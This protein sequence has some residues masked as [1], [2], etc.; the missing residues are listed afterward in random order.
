MYLTNEEE[1]MLKGEQG[2]II[3]KCMKLLLRLGEIYGADRMIKISS[4]QAAGVSYKSIGDPGL[5]FLK[6]FVN[7]GAKVKVPTFLNPA[8]MDLKNW[9]NFGIS[10]NFAEKQLE[11]INTFKKMGIIIACSCTPYLL[12]NL[13]RVGEHIA[14]SESSAVS[15]ANSVIGA[16]TNREGGPSALAA[17]IT[18]RTPNYGFHIDEN[19]KPNFL[20][21]VNANLKT[22]SDYGALGF[23]I[24]KSVKNKVPFFEGIKETDTDKLKSLGAAMA[25]SGGVALYHVLNKTPEAE[26][27]KPTSGNLEKIEFSEKDLK[28]SYEELSDSQN[29]DLIV[30]GCPH[31]SISE[32]E[33]L[34]KKLKNKKLKKEFWI[35]TSKTAK[36]WA[37]RMGYAKILECSG[38]KIICDSCM[39]VSP[40]EETNFECVGTNSGKAA[41]YLPGFCK[42]KVFFGNLDS[43]IEKA[44]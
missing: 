24:G 25:A 12:G 9:K 44:L 35:Y 3:A 5:E 1:G 6:G 19:R 21:K 33:Y 7:E 10:E 18:G 13:P 4:S 22:N 28:K 43:L 23:F 34:T 11:I 20:I 8:G 15:F 2:P 38:A 30:V 41:K 40:L 39:V 31:A 17:A 14:W 27:Y 26:R 29:P 32:I 42:K 36:M 37:D 16:R